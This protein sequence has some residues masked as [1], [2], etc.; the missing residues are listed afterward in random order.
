MIHI[1]ERTRRALG[2]T[3][4]KEAEFRFRQ[5]SWPGQFLWAWR[6][7][8]PAYRIAARLGLLSVLLGIVGFAL[9][10]AGLWIALTD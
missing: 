9:G 3:A 8:D 6:A 7:T 2:L 10:V 1:D 4:G 5:V